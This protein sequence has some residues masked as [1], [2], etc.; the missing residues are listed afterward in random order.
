MRVVNLKTDGAGEHHELHDRY[1]NPKM[2]SHTTST[3]AQ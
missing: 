3:N 2:S 1:I